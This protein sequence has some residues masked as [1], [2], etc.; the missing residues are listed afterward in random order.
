MPINF[1]FLC[2]GVTV[3]KLLMKTLLLVKLYHK[4]NF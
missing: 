1:Q 3:F 2:Q 4:V